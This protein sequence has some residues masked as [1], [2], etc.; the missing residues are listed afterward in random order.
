MNTTKTHH[1]ATDFQMAYVSAAALEHIAKTLA[2]C[3]PAVSGRCHRWKTFDCLFQV[4]QNLP[5]SVCDDI[6]KAAKE[7]LNL[8]QTAQLQ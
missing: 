3:R 2:D 4:C 1:F 6:E 7:Q 5:C 8:H